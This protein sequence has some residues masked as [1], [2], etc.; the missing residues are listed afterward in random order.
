MCPAD[1]VLRVLMGRWKTSILKSIA[2]RGTLHFGALKRELS[3]ISHKVLTRQLRDLEH[4]GILQRQIS[5]K[6]RP[7]MHYS[8]TLRGREL[9][10]VLDSISDLAAR[11]Q[12][13]S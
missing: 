10:E 13:D 4:D 12:A 11:W 1:I 3:G 8:L 7:E 9:Q 5:I 2:D 6:S